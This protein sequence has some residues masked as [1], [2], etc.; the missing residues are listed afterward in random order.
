MVERQLSSYLRNGT[1]RSRSD[2]SLSPRSHDA[3]QQFRALAHHSLQHRSVALD[4][5]TCGIPRFRDAIEL[6]RATRA[7][8]DGRV[9]WNCAR[10]RVQRLADLPDEQLRNQLLGKL[11]QINE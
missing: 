4:G 11:G 3:K 10:L 2:S 8:H 7:C 1:L 5:G 9:S 6:G